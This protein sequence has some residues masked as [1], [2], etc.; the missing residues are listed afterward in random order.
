MSRKLSGA[1]LY[2]V[3]DVREI[4][5]SAAIFDRRVRI[6]SWIPS[7]KYA[8]DLSSLRFSNGKTAMLFSEIDA[9]DVAL[10]ASFRPDLNKSAI[11]AMIMTAPIA[12]AAMR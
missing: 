10:P 4:T 5:F 7:V 3:V 1:L 2:F 6:S 11:A 8:F 12:I 9:R